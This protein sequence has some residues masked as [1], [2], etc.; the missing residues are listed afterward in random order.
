MKAKAK[1]KLVRPDEKPE[2]KAIKDDA[3]EVENWSDDEKSAAYEE[4]ERLYP[5]VVK[6]YENRDEANE[7]IDEFWNIYNAFP[8]D[9]LMYSGN[10]SGYIPAVRDCVD[11]RAKRS[12]KQ[13]FPDRY[14]HVEAVGTAAQVP[15]PQLALLE[16]YIRSSH[17]KSTC[18]SV[19]V[20]GDVTGQWNLYI[21]WKRNYRQVTN[22]I[23][24]NPKLNDGETDLEAV[25]TET[26]EESEENDEI[27]EQG[28]DIVDFATEDLAVIPPTVNNLDDAECTAIKLRLSKSKVQKMVDDG[29]FILPA[30]TE[31]SE[32]MEEVKGQDKTN[33]PRDR[34][35]DAGIRTEGTNKYALIYEAHALLDFGDRDGK[36]SMGYIYYAGPKA[37]VGIVKAPQWGGKRPLI[38]APVERV[39]GSFMGRS[40]IDPVKYLQ[41]NLCDV[42]N[43]G[44]DSATYSLLPVIM[45]DPLKN[46]N[47][48]SMVYGLAAIWSVDPNSTKPLE[49][50]ALYT[51][52]LTICA[53]LKQQIQESMDV[54]EAMLGKAPQGRK[55]SQQMAAAAQE[56]AMNILDHAERFEEEIL[57][58][59]IERIFEYDAQFRKEDVTV[60]T[61]G[62]I[63]VKA[64]MQKIPPQ[65]WGE[66]YHFQWTGTSFIMGQQRMQAQISTMNVLRGIPPQQLNGRRLDVT[67][68]LENLCDNVFGAELS[69][70]ILIDDRNKF[71][72][73]PEIENEMMVNGIPVEV[74]EADNDPEHI[75]K[76]HQAGISNQDPA[77]LIRNHLEKHVEQMQ[78]KRQMMMAQQMQKGQQGAPG[79]GQSGIAGTPRP[80][81]MP[82][83]PRGGQN[84]AGA[85]HP[86]QMA[87]PNVGAR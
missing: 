55:N 66:R 59:L 29:I 56:Q 5:L 62:E 52:A 20:S 35:N 21:D 79:G 78:K 7:A 8:D 39:Q 69:P 80:G 81:A 26:E 24:S 48:A 72:I 41:W 61:Q 42:W 68:V 23:K 49:M 33:P 36:K 53:Q 17:L 50:P 45:T 82:M 28:P 76:H 38:S 65:A 37:I 18:R 64:M 77:G 11:A 3:P 13:L 57:N 58:P 9:N 1:P 84:P 14:R 31:I 63:G 67:P 70:R 47:Y 32:W 4:A 51:H 15:Y 54:N 22:L 74:H 27:L 73:P 16:H 25:D 12:L 86:D 85:T 34:T 83:P 44:Q 6:A 60:L 75:Q 87:D 30:D 2:E 19:L 71:T 46:P 43:M 40:K 10:T